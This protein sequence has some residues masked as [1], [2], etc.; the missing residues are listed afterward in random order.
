MN[1]EVVILLTD[2][3]SFVRYKLTFQ[4]RS[5]LFKGEAMLRG[6]AARR[7]RDVVWVVVT[8]LGGVEARLPCWIGTNN[9]NR[10]CDKA[11]TV[12]NSTECESPAGCPSVLCYSDGSCNSQR[13]CTRQTTH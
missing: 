4:E 12:D 7:I 8:L 2:M 10:G 11:L 13:K 9:W 5:G 3:R 6:V 1:T